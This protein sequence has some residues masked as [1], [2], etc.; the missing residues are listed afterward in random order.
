[1]SLITPE[2]FCTNWGSNPP[3]AFDEEDEELSMKNHCDNIVAFESQSPDC[4]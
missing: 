3:Y 1:M 2:A 4:E